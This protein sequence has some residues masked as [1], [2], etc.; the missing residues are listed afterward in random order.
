LTLIHAAI[1]GPGITPGAL[2]EPP[3]SLV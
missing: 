2:P 1:G 3:R